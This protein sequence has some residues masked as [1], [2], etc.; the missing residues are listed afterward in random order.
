MSKSDINFL[1]LSI[2]DQPWSRNK[3]SIKVSG[4][5]KPKFTRRHLEIDICKT[6]SLIWEKKNV[7][8]VDSPMNKFS[9]RAEKYFLFVCCC[10]FNKWNIRVNWC[11]KTVFHFKSQ[12]TSGAQNLTVRRWWTSADTVMSKVC[13]NFM[14]LSASRDGSLFANT[15]I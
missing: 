7:P 9:E 8:T 15:I 12:R 6:L 1:L 10:F 5:F 2:S 14:I 11:K 13:H 4:C 3:S